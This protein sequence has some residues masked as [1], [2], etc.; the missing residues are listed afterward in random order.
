MEKLK[1]LD[2]SE[3]KSIS[4]GINLAYELGYA[5]GKAAKRAFFIVTCYNYLAE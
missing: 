2:F 3:M 1:E 4:G 5:L